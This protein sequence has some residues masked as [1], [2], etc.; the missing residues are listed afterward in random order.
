MVRRLPRATHAYVLPRAKHKQL[1]HRTR[2]LFLVQD[3]PDVAL[4]H[5]ILPLASVE[6]PQQ[7]P[8]LFLQAPNGV[9]Q[10]LRGLPG[11][12]EGRRAG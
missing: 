12:E 6:L 7:L 9:L 8:D 10:D 4:P 3:P 11:G 1:R 2:A 5:S